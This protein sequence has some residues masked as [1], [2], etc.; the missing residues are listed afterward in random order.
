L[1]VKS[2]SKTDRRC[3]LLAHPVQLYE[4]IQTHTHN[5]FVANEQVKLC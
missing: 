3:F 4:H 1:S 2:E 5:H